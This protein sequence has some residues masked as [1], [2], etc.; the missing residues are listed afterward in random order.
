[1]IHHMRER[2]KKNTLLPYIKLITKHLLYFGYDLED[3][4][5][6]IKRSKI[7][8]GSLSQMRFK[9]K[10]REVISLPPR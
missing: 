8:K 2:K 10:N 4:E 1:M 6:D 7:G 9:I 5:L 3:K